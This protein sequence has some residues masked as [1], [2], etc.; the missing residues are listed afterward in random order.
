MPELMR[1]RQEDQKLKTILGYIVRL[2]PAAICKTLSQNKLK[3][4]SKLC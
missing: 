2:K 3:N 1:R 4:N